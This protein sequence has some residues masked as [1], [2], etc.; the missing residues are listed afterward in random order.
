MFEPV[1]EFGEA[2]DVSG[3]DDTGSADGLPYNSGHL[4]EGG[5]STHRVHE[6][7]VIR[8][9]GEEL[10][11]AEVVLG[12]E[13]NGVRI[14]E[15]QFIDGV[16]GHGRGMKGAACGNRIFRKIRAKCLQFGRVLT[17]TFE[18]V[19]PQIHLRIPGIDEGNVRRIQ[20]HEGNVVAEMR[21]TAA[22]KFV[23]EGGFA[24]PGRSA[25]KNG[26]ARGRN[27]AAVEGQRAALV[28][29]SA[30]NRAEDEKPDLRIGRA[31]NALYDDGIAAGNEIAGGVENAQKKLA[32]V[33]LN[34]PERG[35]RFSKGFRHTAEFD[36]DVCYSIGGRKE[37]GKF[38]GGGK[39]ETESGV[40]SHRNGMFI[41]D[42][43][44]NTKGGNTCYKFALLET[45]VF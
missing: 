14:A 11:F 2:K 22:L 7:G 42:N 27:P 24:T 31:G 9:A 26:A 8:V 17:L 40:T 10:Q 43:T 5:T 32:R 23:G 30:H 13:F 28:Q 36:S 39:G 6:T 34:P 37:L 18:C 12:D 21:I 19:C 16:E 45:E 1:G 4:K 33:D 35:G 41:H 44:N 20:A 29:E 38:E 25:K 3:T 15:L